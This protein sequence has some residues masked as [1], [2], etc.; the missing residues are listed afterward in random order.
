M[1]Q[2][3]KIQH[4]IAC[5]VELVSPRKTRNLKHRREQKS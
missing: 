1:A 2:I 4:R 5:R 3:R